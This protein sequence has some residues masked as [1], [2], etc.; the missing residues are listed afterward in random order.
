MAKGNKQFWV[1]PVEKAA[2]QIFKAIN[3]KK[4]RVYITRR[5]WLIAKLM[6]LMP[7]TIYKKFA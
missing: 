5:W 3:Y 7:Y 4:R 1:A 6:K 2:R